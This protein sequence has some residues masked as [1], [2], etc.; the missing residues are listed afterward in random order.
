MKRIHMLEMKNHF[1]SLKKNE[2]ILDVRTPGEFA[3]GHVEGARNIPV[4]RVMNHVSEL[5]DF[6]AIYVYCAAGMRSQSACQ[7]LSTL[8]LN[9]LVCIDDGGY[10]DW[11][12][13]G[14]PVK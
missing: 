1:D 6:E 13:A 11:S 7:I 12:D 8:G 3:G 10:E 9:N 5:K 14:F 4:D 2:L